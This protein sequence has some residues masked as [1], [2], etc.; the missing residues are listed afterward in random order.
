MNL[1][2]H[3][4]DCPYEALIQGEEHVLDKTLLDSKPESNNGEGKQ[5][6]SQLLVPDT[7]EKEVEKEIPY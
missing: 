2:G 3:E 4:G 6:Y 5:S 1:E 7:P